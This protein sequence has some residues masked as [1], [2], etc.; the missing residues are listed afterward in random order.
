MMSG[1]IPLLQLY[2][3]QAE[4]G[5]SADFQTMVHIC[6]DAVMEFLEKQQFLQAAQILANLVC[7]FMLCCLVQPRSKKVYRFLFKRLPT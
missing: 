7:S 5:S 2:L 3:V 6:L 1:D 4:D